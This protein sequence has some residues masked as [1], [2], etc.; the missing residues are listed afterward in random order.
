[1]IAFYFYTLVYLHS[2][3]IERKISMQQSNVGVVMVISSRPFSLYKLFWTFVTY[4]NDV[5]KYKLWET[6]YKDLFTP[7]YVLYLDACL[8]S[9]V[10]TQPNSFAFGHVPSFYRLP[11]GI[12]IKYMHAHKLVVAWHICLYTIVCN[13]TNVD[14][15]E[16]C[17]LHG[18]VR[19]LQ[20][21]L[22]T[23][24]YYMVEDRL[25]LYYNHSTSWI[26]SYNI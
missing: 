9:V 7:W 11:W 21:I 3:S 19:Y 4:C 5:Y 26:Q 20:V 2:A 18:P 13:W 12:N 14:Y 23:L 1:M 6:V 16:V 10:W 8:H 24:M 25:L 15:I 22:C 17:Q